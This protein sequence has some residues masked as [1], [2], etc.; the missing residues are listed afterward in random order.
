SSAAASP[1][2]ST[3][4][5]ALMSTSGVAPTGSSSTSLLPEGAAAAVPGS[6]DGDAAAA[7]TYEQSPSSMHHEEGNVEGDSVAEAIRTLDDF[8]PILDEQTAAVLTGRGPDHD[9]SQAP[10]LTDH[11]Q[12]NQ[13]QE[14][15]IAPQP[16]AYNH[17]GHGPYPTFPH[18]IPP[19][20]VN[21]V[22]HGQSGSQYPYVANGSPVPPVLQPPYPGTPASS[23]VPPVAA[24]IFPAAGELQG[25]TSTAEL[26]LLP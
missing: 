9:P 8:E 5:P 18:G 12:Q 21:Y 15:H 4:A 16:V 6:I 11:Q 13:W 23:V 19:S 10:L 22:Q 26:P 20:L 24:P 3:G 2:S 1:P 25:A 17:Q 7:P 14:Q